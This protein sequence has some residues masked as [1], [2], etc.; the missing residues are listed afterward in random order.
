MKILMVN[1]FLYPN[2]GSE[3]YMFKLGEYLESTGHQ[4]EYF[5]MEH[6]DR[7]VSNSA[8]CYTENMDFHDSGAL[9]KIPLAFKTVYS[10]EARKKIRKV[11]ENFK[12]DIVHLNNFNYQITPSV[13][14]EIRKWEKETKHSVKIIYTAHD[15]QLI[16]PNHMLNN[17]NTGENCEKCIGGRY[18]NCIKGKCIHGSTLKSA[19]G[20]AEAAYW[21]NKKTYAQIDKIICCSNFMKSKLDTNPIFKTKTVALHN[22][23]DVSENN[24]LEKKDYILYFGRFSQEKGIDTLIK[25]CSLMPEVKF[26]FAGTGPLESEIEKIP[27]AENVGFKS[28]DELKALI[29]QAKASVYPSIWY[30]NCPLSVMES[31]SYGTPVIGADIGGIPELVENGKNGLLFKAG[32]AQDLASKISLIFSDATVADKITNGCKDNNFMSV[33]EYT[34]KYLELIKQ[35]V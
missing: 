27:N 35:N 30:E 12:P 22:F 17:P 26:V 5:G 11:L 4:V 34:E 29:S 1:K 6:P 20:F 31:I 25:V 8:D 16:C 19:I 18:I 33:R 3:T 23:I 7:C 21:N 2:G 13:I 9:K 32:D 14:P 15:Y 24:K 10:A 28:G